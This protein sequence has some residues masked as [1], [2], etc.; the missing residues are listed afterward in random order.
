[1][2]HKLPFGGVGNSGYSS[3]HG[4]I[5]FNNCSHLKPVLISDAKDAYP[6]HVKFPPY[7]NSKVSLFEKVGKIANVYRG[8]ILKKVAKF[9]ALA[10]FAGYAYCHF[11]C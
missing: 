1:M 6:N 3:L 7:T 4:Q 11:N 5:G 8:E 10:I 2:N 9:G